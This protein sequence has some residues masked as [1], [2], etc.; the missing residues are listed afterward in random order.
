MSNTMKK[1]AIS[2][3]TASTV[4]ITAC[5]MNSL[6]EAQAICMDPSTNVR[7]DDDFCEEDERNFNGSPWVYFLAG[8]AI[9]AVGAAMSPNS[10][11]RTIPPGYKVNYADFPDSGGTFSGRNPNGYQNNSAPTTTK[12]KK[13]TTLKKPTLPKKTR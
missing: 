4:L 11:H 5:G 1:T 13:K 3:L 7:I 9:P 2:V 8:A 12:V 6:D 10:F